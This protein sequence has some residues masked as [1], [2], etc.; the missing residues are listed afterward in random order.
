MWLD[1][2]NLPLEYANLSDERSTKLRDRWVGPFETMKQAA[3]SNAWFLNL[4]STWR[5]H[6]PINASRLKE[7]V[8]DPSR[9]RHP[10]SLRRTTAGAEW[11][12]ERL[13]AHRT[14][15]EGV[16]EYR[17]QWEGY[18][19]EQDTWEPLSSLGG[20]KEALADYLRVTQTAERRKGSRL[21]K[22]R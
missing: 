3:S 12:V 16:D 19:P 9:P 18:P 15:P 21:R 5:I 7:D 10:P 4:P 14:T 6:Q 20:A 17:I 1:T 11:A 22:R 8:S 2:E 13:V